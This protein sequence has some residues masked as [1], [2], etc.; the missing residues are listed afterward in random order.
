MV[1]GTFEPAINV[2]LSAVR[3]EIA[4]IHLDGT[5]MVSHLTENHTKHIRKVSILQCDAESLS[6]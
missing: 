6:N 3:E 4:L 2:E 5:F 1:P